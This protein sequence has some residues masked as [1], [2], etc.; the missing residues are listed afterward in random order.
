MAGSMAGSMAAALALLG[1]AGP[2]A[3]LLTA[4]AL[5]LAGELPATRV[6]E[7]V[8]L[9][10]AAVGAAVGWWLAGSALLVLCC[11]LA[12][13]LGTRWRGAEALALRVAPAVLRRTL[14]TAVGAGLVL[15][16][17]LAPASA[18]GRAAV[19][20]WPDPGWQTTTTAPATGP[21][22]AEG[23]GA[24]ADAPPTSPTGRDGWSAAT[25]SSALSPFSATA[26]DTDADRT[27][28]APVTPTADD[29]TDR[30]QQDGSVVVR[31][32]D[33]LWAIAASRLPA[34]ATDAQIAQEWPRWYAEN[35]DVVGTDP[36]LILPGQVL[37]QPD[38]PPSPPERQ[39]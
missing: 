1:F 35:L 23:S 9:G 15:G 2:V 34:G 11:L 5:R 4:M 16:V 30:D 18:T 3:A 12:R 29:G 39:G 10:A 31:P 32:G 19:P 13:G 7:L 38:R 20:S 36:G 37:R 6:E 24:A 8:A 14:V 17:G 27:G 28:V 22:P 21:A 33:S 26:V 25:P